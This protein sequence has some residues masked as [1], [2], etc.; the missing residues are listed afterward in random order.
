MKLYDK[1]KLNTYTYERN[2]HLQLNLRCN[3]N[4]RLILTF[5][6]CLYT[7]LDYHSNINRLIY[8]C[9]MYFLF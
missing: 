5:E 2:M 8:N 4:A 9:F 6:L 1:M 7:Y 3:F